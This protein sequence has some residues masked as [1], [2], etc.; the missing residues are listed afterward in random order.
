MTKNQ[1]NYTINYNFFALIDAE[2]KKHP[3]R[4]RITK[5]YDRKDFP[6]EYNPRSFYH[7]KRYREFKHCANY[8]ISLKIMDDKLILHFEWD[9]NIFNK[10]YDNID[11][12]DNKK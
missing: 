7:E 4:C 9:E 3:V 10:M 12:L 6:I 5:E 8:E 2:L 11:E 1:I